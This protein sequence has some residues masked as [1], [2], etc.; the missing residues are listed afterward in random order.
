MRTRPLSH[1]QFTGDTGVLPLHRVDSLAL[2]GSGIRA[3]ILEPP[4]SNNQNQ[5]LQT[6]DALF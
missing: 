6:R 3:V 4:G 1:L 5:T 2:L